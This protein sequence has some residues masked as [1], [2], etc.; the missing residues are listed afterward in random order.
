M[1]V[2]KISKWLII[3][4]KEQ[5]WHDSVDNIRGLLTK[6]STQRATFHSSTLDRTRVSSEVRSEP[7]PHHRSTRPARSPSLSRPSSLRGKPPC[8]YLGRASERRRGSWSLRSLSRL[9]PGDPSASMGTG[10]RGGWTW[11]TRSWR[12]EYSAAMCFFLSVFAVY[13]LSPVDLFG[14]VD[15]SVCMIP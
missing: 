2:L 8:D 9:S 3:W 7:D 11:R 14:L 5:K 4:N 13:N 12:C 1:C 15:R 10:A 6:S